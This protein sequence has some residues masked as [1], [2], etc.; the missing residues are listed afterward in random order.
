M[1]PLNYNQLYYFYKIASLGSIS[2][3][4]KTLLISSPALSMQLKELE[5]SLGTPL[6]IRSGKKLILT[7]AGSIVFEYASDIFKLGYELRDTIGDRSNHPGRLRIEIGCQDSIPKMVVDELVAFLISEKKCQV[8]LREGNRERLLQMQNE[9]KLD[10]VLTNSVPQQENDYLSEARLLT[11]EELI[12]VG[13]AKWKSIKSGWPQRLEQVPMVLPTFDSST[14]QKLEL[15]FKEHKLN[16]DKAT[17]HDLAM[18]GIGV[19]TGMKSG[20]HN[21]LKEKKLVELGKLAGLN[22][23][24][25]MLMGKR[26]ILNPL[27]LFAMK[28]FSL[29]LHR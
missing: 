26:K 7:D 16:I 3:A 10:L 19:I 24:I 23:E 17:E 22:E 29:E 5:E 4:S 9:Y 13:H 18:R 11:R 28:N 1:I 27:A 21:L 8:M 6:F 20:V 15:Y 12:V 2:Q 14:R 25:W